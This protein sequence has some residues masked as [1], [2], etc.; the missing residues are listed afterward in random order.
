ME[1][2]RVADLEQ[3]EQQRKEWWDGIHELNRCGVVIPYQYVVGL[4]HG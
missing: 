4:H 3:R 1:L 2:P